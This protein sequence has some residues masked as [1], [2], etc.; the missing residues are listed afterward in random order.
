MF[1]QYNKLSGSQGVITGFSLSDIEHA[2][3]CE[4]PIRLEVFNCSIWGT[5]KSNNYIIK[6]HENKCFH[7]HVFERASKF[8]SNLDEAVLSNNFRD[9]C[10]GRIT[11]CLALRELLLDSVFRILS[12]CHS[13]HFKRFAVS[14]LPSKLL[15]ACL[16]VGIKAS[17]GDSFDAKRLLCFESV[18]MILITAVFDYNHR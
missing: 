17:G 6:W 14:D 3:L 8:F 15:Q 4:L 7:L 11:N 16:L 1:W 18:M 10:F 12:T 9:Q 5:Q 13:C 2:T